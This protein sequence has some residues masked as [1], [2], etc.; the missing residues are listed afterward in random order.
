MVFCKVLWPAYYKYQP[1]AF[2]YKTSQIFKEK[3]YKKDIIAGGLKR[4]DNIYKFKKSFARKGSY[5]FFIGKKVH[6][7]EIYQKLCSAWEQK[8]PNLK[9]NYKNFLLKYR[10]KN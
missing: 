6:N 7:E 2:A 5:E 4:G 1:L 8:Y 3:G 9:D 10:E